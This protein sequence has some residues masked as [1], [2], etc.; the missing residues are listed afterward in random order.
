MITGWNAAAE[1]MFGMTRELALGRP[2]AETIV[3]PALRDAHRAG[4][5]GSSPPARSG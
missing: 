2:L 3:P 5:A 4:L 1:Q